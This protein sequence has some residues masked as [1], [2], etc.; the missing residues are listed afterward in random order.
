[1][2]DLI[3]ARWC[4]EAFFARLLVERVL[5]NRHQFVEGA[6]V[7]ACGGGSQGLLDEVIARDV[8]RIGRAHEGTPR[9][10]VACFARKART[11]A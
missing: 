4:R 10:R 6:K 7:T 9:S 5:E 1:M 3:G 2:H 11:P 8:E